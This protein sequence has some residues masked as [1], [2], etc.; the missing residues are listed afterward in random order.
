MTQRDL[1]RAR[2]RADYAAQLDRAYRQGWQPAAHCKMALWD[3]AEV[4]L[5][6]AAVVS[7]FFMAVL[8]ALNFIGGK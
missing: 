2:M 1:I 7:V 6:F 5:G 3:A 4:A 8:W